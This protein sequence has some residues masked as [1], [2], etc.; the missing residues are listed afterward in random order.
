MTLND[1]ERTMVCQ[2]C[3]IVAT[4][5]DAITI[6]TCVEHDSRFLQ[7]LHDNSK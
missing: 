7:S 5:K 2:L 3:G 1:L 4:R 6:T